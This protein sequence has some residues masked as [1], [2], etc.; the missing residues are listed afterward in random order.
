MADP[1]LRQLD[2]DNLFDLESER[3]VLSSMLHAEDAC[4]KPIMP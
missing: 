1:V 4:V 2:E 3:R